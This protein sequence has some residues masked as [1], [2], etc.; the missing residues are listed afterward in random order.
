M[1]SNKLYWIIGAAVVILFVVF[2]SVLFSRKQVN[3]E[4]QVN[5]PH[6]EQNQGVQMDSATREDVVFM[7]GEGKKVSIKDLQGKVV[8]INFWATWCP[9]CINEMPSI[10]TLKSKFESS[11]DIVFLMVDVDAKY[12]KSNAFMKD[13]NYNL[14]VYI[15]A[16]QIPSTFLGSAIPTTVILNKKGELSQRLEGGRDY[17]SQ[18]IE[19][20]LKELIALK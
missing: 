5:A 12:E 16:S 1:K 14:P 8:F 18:E 11:K 19:D 10:N 6:V 9:P 2:V 17:A 7:D 3:Q 20:Y 4:T 15:P 13:N